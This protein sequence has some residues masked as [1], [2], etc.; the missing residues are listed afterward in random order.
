[1]GDP[2]SNSRAVHSYNK[3]H[4]LKGLCLKCPNPAEPSKLLCKSCNEKHRKRNAVNNPVYLQERIE[5]RLCVRC[6]SPLIE[7][8]GR[9]C[10]NCNDH[11][12]REAVTYAARGVRFTS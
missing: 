7:G 5:M 2:T 4:F 1:M 10:G 6:G 3:R 11:H 12:F 8:E 9:T